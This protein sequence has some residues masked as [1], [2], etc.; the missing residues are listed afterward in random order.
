[1]KSK[2]TRLEISTG[3]S[4]GRDTYGYTIVR[5]RDTDTGHIYRTCGGG[6]CMTGT[7]LGDWLSNV[8]QDKLKAYL[9]STG[10]Q[11]C[12]HASSYDTATS[13]GW[14]YG[15]GINKKGIAYFDG[16][17]GDDNTETL[18]KTLGLEIEP[19]YT[20]NKRG[21]KKFLGWLVSEPLPETP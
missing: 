12:D 2:I 4:R 20:K 1:M 3:T 17:T 15:A 8:Y 19:Y 5:L 14:F 10:M 18:I 6:Y 13:K 9:T 11:P 21:H 7:V 16:A